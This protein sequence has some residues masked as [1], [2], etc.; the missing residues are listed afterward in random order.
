MLFASQVAP[1]LLRIDLRKEARSALARLGGADLNLD[2]DQSHSFPSLI[3]RGFRVTGAAGKTVTAVEAELGGNAT[4]EGVR[5]GN[6]RM[7][8]T[9]AC[10]L[11]AGNEVA[12]SCLR[13]ALADAAR[14]IGPE[15]GDPID[16]MFIVENPRRRAHTPA[17]AGIT[18]AAIVSS[19]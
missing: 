7:P 14:I 4:I 3:S 2:P 16:V 13:T 11:D 12:V 15:L 5:R 18:L 10:M 19:C 6:A 17:N 1:R 8:V 9:G